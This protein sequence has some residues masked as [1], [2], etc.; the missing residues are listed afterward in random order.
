MAFGPSGSPARLEY[1]DLDPTLF[2]R[3]IQAAE[4]PVTLL[5]FERPSICGRFFS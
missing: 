1:V 3:L 4:E 5:S 2:A